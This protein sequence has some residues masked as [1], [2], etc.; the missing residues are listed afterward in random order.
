MTALSLLPEIARGAGIGFTELVERIILSAALK[1]GNGGYDT[2]S[3][4]MT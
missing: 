3:I 4:C 2:G 1:I